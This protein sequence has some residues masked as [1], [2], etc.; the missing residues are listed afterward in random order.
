MRESGFNFGLDTYPIFDENYRATLNKK[1]LDHYNFREIGFETA[2]M[3]KFYLNT[4]MN[5]IMPYYNKLY[6][7]E[8]LTFNPLYNSKITETLAKTNTVESIGNSQSN[9]NSNA[10]GESQQSDKNIFNETPQGNIDITEID[11]LNYATN[12][13]VNKNNNTSSTENAIVDNSTT[14][15][16]INNIEDYTKVVEGNS[17]MSNSAL[18]I[19]FRNTFLNIDL[20][21]IKKL[22]DLFMGLWE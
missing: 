13:T 22:N 16:N 12:Y 5:E 10:T 1:I 18:L 3:F 17:G 8:L 21:I 4:V 7:S 9:S 20:E 6:N 2:G 11:D 14:E 15:S 19:E